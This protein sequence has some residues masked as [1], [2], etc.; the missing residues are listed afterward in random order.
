MSTDLYHLQPAHCTHLAGGIAR[1]DLGP[2]EHERRPQI[3]SR[4]LQQLQNVGEDAHA[5]CQIHG[6]GAHVQETPQ[7]DER[8]QPVHLAEQDLQREMKI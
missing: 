2:D 3:R 4:G 5:E 1:Q 7:Q 8:S 6:P